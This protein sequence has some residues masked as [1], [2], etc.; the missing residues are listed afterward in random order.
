MTS[1]GTLIPVPL[2]EKEEA[3]QLNEILQ[4]NTVE[5]RDPNVP[6]LEGVGPLGLELQ[7]RE[8][9]VVTKRKADMEAARARGEGHSTQ[10]GGGS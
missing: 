2:I 1:T 5:M 8:L 4:R 7:Q 3:L 6:Y 9:E 10:G